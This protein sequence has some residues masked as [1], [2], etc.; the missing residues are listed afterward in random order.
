MRKSP[1]TVQRVLTQ[2]EKAG[3]IKRIARFRGHK[4]QTS[5]AYA[6]D[7]VASKLIALEPEFRKA[8]EQNKIRR[9]K[10]EA[11]TAA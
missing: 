10:V 2:L 11:G 8:T 5:N 3:H 6:L 9:R 1:R 4:A 7:G